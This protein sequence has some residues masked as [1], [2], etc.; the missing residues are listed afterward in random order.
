VKKFDKINKY[1]EGNK[2]KPIQE[3]VLIDFLPANKFL[4]HTGKSYA[5]ETIVHFFESNEIIL[6]NFY[7][8]RKCNEACTGCGK[9]DWFIWRNEFM[10]Y[11]TLNHCLISTEDD[12]ELE[13]AP[14]LEEIDFAV[15][16][17]P[18]CGAWFTVIA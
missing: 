6:K 2:G 13:D 10:Y 14:E 17:C 3:K 1:M 5:Y 4:Y 15:H 8:A 16:V 9:N 18:E 11:D 12:E 7:R